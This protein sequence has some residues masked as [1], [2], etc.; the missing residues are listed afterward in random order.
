MFVPFIGDL[1]LLNV[2]VLVV[3]L[4]ILWVIVSIPV[5]IAGKIVT[6]GEST[7]GDAMG[8]T[9]F[10]PTIYT[11]TLLAMNLLLGSVVGS[12][13]YIWA[14]VLAFIAWVWVFK[15][16]F[17][18]GWLSAL[19]IAVLAILVFVVISLLFG[20]LLGVMVPAPFFPRF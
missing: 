8:A 11:A 12:E 5:Y 3:G 18:T 15:A 4:V 9:L 13:G 2:L 20:A 16:S 17:H 14:L 7:L 1:T 6:G 19:S 10:G